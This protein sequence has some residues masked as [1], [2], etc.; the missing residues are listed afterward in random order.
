[1]FVDPC[2]VEGTCFETIKKVMACQSSEAFV[3]FNIDGVRRIF[4]LDD[5]VTCSSNSLAQGPAPRHSPL[6]CKVNT[7]PKNESR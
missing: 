4:G 2:G 3:F 6:H 7:A 5:L 1:V